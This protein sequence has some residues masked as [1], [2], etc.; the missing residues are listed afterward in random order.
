[1]LALIQGAKRG[2]SAWLP[3]DT[4]IAHAETA[5]DDWKSSN[6]WV[7]YEMRLNCVLPRYDHVI[8]TYDVNLL[9]APLAVDILRAHPVVV[10][11]GSLGR[12]SFF[13]RRGDFI[14]EV[15]ARLGP[16][17]PYRA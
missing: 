12:D 17:Q 9:T 8:C 10:I 5:V 13:T 14:R 4:M 1:M 11:G 6:E 7:E 2:I 3:V 15:Q 16:T